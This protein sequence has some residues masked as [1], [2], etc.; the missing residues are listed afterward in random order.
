LAISIGVVSDVRRQEMGTRL[1]DLVDANF[2]TVDDGTLGCTRNHAT[3]WRKHA[4]APAGWNLN[5]EDD[6]VPVDMFRDQLEKA[7]N[8]APAPIVSLYL[9]GGYIG[10]HLT[11]ALLESPEGMDAHWAVTQGAVFHAVAVAV[12]GEI[13]PPIIKFL[14]GQTRPVD[15]M[16]SS[17][18]TRNSYQIAYSIPSLVD[19]ADEK[20]LV[21]KYRRSPRRAFKTGGR[22]GWCSKLILMY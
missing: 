5:L 19:H 1:A 17:W 7:L 16:L 20:S 2:L 15:S 13:L 12:R 22:E 6:A 9:G 4:Q 3:A 18:A 8:V 11:R 21:T 10:D 14:E